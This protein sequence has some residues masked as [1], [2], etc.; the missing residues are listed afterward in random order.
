MPTYRVTDSVTGKTL[1]LTGD[2]APTEQ[3][4][5]DIFKSY[6]PK[7]KRDFITPAKQTAETVAALVTGGTSW[8]PAG[9]SMGLPTI[10]KHGI[11]FIPR[12]M[13]E[14]EKRS[15]RALKI[16][17]KLT[18]QPKDKAAQRAVEI[19]AKPITYLPEKGKEKAEHFRKLGDEAYEN[20]DIKTAKMYWALGGVTEFAGEASPF[21][22]PAGVGK[23]VK[24]IKT[25]VNKF[26]AQFEEPLG[27]TKRTAVEQVPE[28]KTSAVI[29][30]ETKTK[31]PELKTQEKVTE[32]K[33]SQEPSGVE[34]EV[35]KTKEIKP[36]TPEDPLIAEAR[37]YKTAEEFVEAQPVFYHGS[38]TKIENYQKGGE[39]T[40]LGGLAK[41]GYF[42]GDKK[43]ATR[44]ANDFHPKNPVVNEAILNIKKPLVLSA[45]EFERLQKLVGKI[46]R[47]ET[48]TELQDIGREMFFNEHGL[49][50]Y[51]QHPI[52]A[53]KKAGYDAIQK[54]AGRGG[55]EAET[56]IFDPSQIKTKSQL[57]DIWNKAQEK[58][59]PKTPEAA[60]IAE[61]TKHDNV[62]D[63]IANA[64]DGYV[65]IFHDKAG[66]GAGGQVEKGKFFVSNIS[67]P[68]LKESE[69]VYYLDLPI[70]EAKNVLGVDLETAHFM[71]N[72]KATGWETFKGDNTTTGA[73]TLPDK[74]Y[75]QLKPKSKLIEFWNKL[76][77]ERAL[78]AEA[79]KYKTAEEFVEAQG[80]TVYHGTPSKELN[81]GEQPIGNQLP[82]GVHFQEHIPV[83]KRFADGTTKVKPT[84]NEGTIYESIMPKNPLNIDKGLFYEGTK[85]FAILKEIAEKSKIKDSKY[86][87][88]YK[89]KVAIDPMSIFWKRGQQAKLDV[90]KDVLTKNGYDQAIVYGMKGTVDP[91]GV[92]APH[93]TPAVA[94]L[95][96]SLIKTKSQLIDI[97]NKAQE[98]GSGTPKGGTPE[99]PK[100]P[101]TKPAKA[102]L[103]INKKLAEKGLEQLPPEELAQYPTIK[104]ND[105]VQKVVD[106]LTTDEKAIIDAS[107][108]KRPFPEDVHP[109]VAFNTVEKLANSRGDIDLLLALEK[110]PVAT[111]RSLMAQGLGASAWNKLRGSFVEKLKTIRREREKQIKADP[112]KVTKAKRQIHEE[113]KKVLLNVE[114]LSWNKFLKDIVC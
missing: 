6:T 54:K 92:G 108:G 52:D 107:L 57:T 105:I 40:T 30:E 27:L 80:K 36:S 7:K 38:G 17:E 49:G 47:G 111:Q 18:Y 90:I 59:A 1:K 26:K 99:T 68:L 46:D 32:S 83:A 81:F 41:H 78:I 98:G 67:E 33:L 10:E 12:S 70:E 44:Y 69:N 5:V 97:W 109:Q 35:D 87:I 21:L 113:T 77:E 4:L 79:R 75:A 100:S 74:Y 82:F 76:K 39:T 114:E 63:F 19:I 9:L 31:S 61:A 88:E 24:G 104:Q 53:I 51:V 101:Q 3:E 8:I 110:S 13:E 20:G 73:A 66:V 102:A 64:P 60:L 62:D 96:K 72:P 91:L 56:M 71:D 95:D 25:K 43:T 106:A 42:F 112:E 55:A 29:P 50:D 93:Y 14:L 28:A 37:K 58:T 15:E 84:G 65:R 16:Q 89:G 23:G 85:E 103:D 48:L 2:S 34:S 94:I 45:I 86:I 22:I 11:S